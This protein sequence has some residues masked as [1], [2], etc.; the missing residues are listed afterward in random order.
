MIRPPHA[1]ATALE[2]RPQPRHVLRL[3]LAL[4]AAIALAVAPLSPAP[5]LADE[6]PT[7]WTVA[8]F[9]MIEHINAD[10]RAHG[11]EALR[12]DVD[13]REIARDWSETM[14]DD[15][16]R[17]RPEFWD[18]YPDGW[19]SAGENIG[20]SSTRTNLERTTEW[21]HGAF[22]DSP[23]H[24]D[25]ILRDGF[26]H[27]GVG[28]HVDERDVVWF[29][30]NFMGHPERAA[31]EPEPEP[32]QYA[33][34][35]SVDD[36]STDPDDGTKDAEDDGTED[37]KDDGTEDGKDDGVFVDVDEKDVHGPA[38]LR[39]A[40]E[41]VI[42]GYDDGTFRPTLSVTRAQLATLLVRQLDLELDGD[43]P[44][45]DDVAKDHPHAKTIAIA[46]S[47][48]VVSGYDDGTFRPE[49]DL[50]R[51]QAATMLVRAFEVA[52][53]DGHDFTDVGDSVH[54]EA[55]AA[56]AAHGMVGGYDDGTF[57]PDEALTRA[58]IATILDR[59][60]D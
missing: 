5:A 38:I 30:V 53:A 4:L 29:T 16:F 34:G 58:Q 31:E 51:A 28:V 42:T 6:W 52:E 39:M 11:L 12:V 43:V 36:A 27:V 10:R 47:H 21:M 35:S 48:G 1:E 60:A 57:R 13:V 9:Q 50:T 22:M 7:D 44:T 54:A 55:I 41:G 33:S 49:R 46:A 24:R 45:F 14:A 15:G 40:A 18:L 59:L 3:A 2:A 8:E 32:G 56:A 17:H 25:N 19:R 26:T 20:Y 37:V 23:G